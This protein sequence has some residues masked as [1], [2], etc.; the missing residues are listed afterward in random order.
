[1][2]S[3]KT[4]PKSSATRPSTSSNTTF[5][6]KVSSERS[7]AK[8]NAALKTPKGRQA[9]A[10]YSQVPPA[11]SAAP[12]RQQVG[13]AS[14]TIIADLPYSSAHNDGTTTAG[15]GHKTTIPQRQFIGVLILVLVERV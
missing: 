11:T 10:R 14:V 15:R 6:Q 7:G 1:M 8:S 9:D 3:A 4:C 5:R 12:S 2:P 13:D